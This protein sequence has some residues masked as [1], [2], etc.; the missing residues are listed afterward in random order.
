MNEDPV[1]LCQRHF[2]STD[3]SKEESIQTKGAKY[4][5]GDR[6]RRRIGGAKEDLWAEEWRRKRKQGGVVRSIKVASKEN[7]MS[8]PAENI[9]FIHFLCPNIIDFCLDIFLISFIKA[10]ELILCFSLHYLV[11]VFFVIIKSY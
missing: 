2:L 5:D 8:C 1:E 7:E 9:L 10:F 6:E 11:F 4:T 3:E